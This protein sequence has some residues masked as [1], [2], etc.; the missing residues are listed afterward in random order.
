MVSYE[1]LLEIALASH[2]PFRP[3][4]REQ[5][6]SLVLV[7][8]AEQARVA[9]RVCRKLELERVR[10]L[11]TRVEPLK[12]F[13]LAEDYH[14]KYYLRNDDILMADFRAMFATDG[15]FRDSTAAARVNGYVAGDG[16]RQLLQR[17]I[18]SLGLTEAGRVHLAEQVARCAAHGGCAL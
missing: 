8:D 4:Y 18:G 12:R 13:Y 16:S 7:H 14:Q 11:S 5:Y 6:A 9:D 1:Q 17:D 15:A 3:A 10:R 2:D